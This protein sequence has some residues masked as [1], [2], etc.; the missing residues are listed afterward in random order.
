[1]AFIFADGFD[2]YQTI[3]QLWDTTTGTGPFTMSSGNARF[4][5][6]AGLTGQGIGIGQN[7]TVLKN[8]PANIVT[9]IVGFAWKTSLAL[10]GTNAIFILQ[11]AGTNQVCLATT[12]AG[13][14]QFYRGAPTTNPIGA[15]SAPGLY[16]PGIWH[17][18]EIVVTID[19]TVGT[20]ALYI[21][22]P[23]SGSAAIS[24]TSLNTRAS[25]NSF[26][27]Q[28]VMSVPNIGTTESFDDLYVYDATTGTMN[29]RIGDNRIITK[30]PN[31][32]GGLTQWTPNG[33]ASN[34]LCVNEIPPDDD[35]TYVSDNTAGHQDAYAMQSAGI[36][37]TPNFV[38]VRN[39]I[40]K[41]DAAAHTAAGLVRSAGVVGVGTAFTVPS[42]YQ[43]FDTLFINDPNTSAPW[44]ASAADAT[45]VGQ[46]IVT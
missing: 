25:A 30:M 32:A 45:Q 16:T 44:T 22:Q 18:L 19:P 36:T 40:R 29:A 4:T 23:S 10:A 43:F 17:Y 46:K 38:V 31:G 21:D 12:A 6:P 7:S 34:Y 9:C 35:T 27:N 2:N 24:S 5:A 41:D 39:R 1:M 11:D 20:V 8:L 3:T 28:I 13:G 26:A 42:S 15:A 37:A 33:A 14:F